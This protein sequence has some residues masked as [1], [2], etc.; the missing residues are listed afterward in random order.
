MNINYE[1][2]YKESANNTF[3]D[4]HKQNINEINNG[5]RNI[6]INSNEKKK[7]KNENCIWAK[8]FKILAKEEKNGKELLK[9]LINL[10]KYHVQSLNGRFEYKADFNI[11]VATRM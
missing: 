1:W 5:N 6:N 2:W 10:I 8:A 7:E 9:N 3:E 11:N 4:I